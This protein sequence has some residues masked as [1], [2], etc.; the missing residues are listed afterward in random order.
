MK[1]PPSVEGVELHL[2]FGGDAV[3]VLLQDR[4]NAWCKSWRRPPRRWESRSRTLV[5][6]WGRGAA[7]SPW[8]PPPPVIPPCPA[9]PPCGSRAR[10]ARPLF[11][12]RRRPPGRRARRTIRSPP[13]G[14][15]R[16][17]RSTRCRHSTPRHPT[18]RGTGRRATGST[19]ATEHAA[20]RCRAQRPRSPWCRRCGTAAAARAPPLPALAAPTAGAA[21]PEAPAAPP[22]PRS[23]T[24]AVT[25][26]GRRKNKSRLTPTRTST[27]LRKVVNRSIFPVRV[28]SQ[29]I[30]RS[31]IVF[32]R[33]QAMQV[34]LVSLLGLR[35][36][37]P[38]ACSRGFG[39]SLLIAASLV[40]L[41][42]GYGGD[43]GGEAAG[44]GRSCTRTTAATTGSPAH[45]RPRVPV[46][47]SRTGSASTRQVGAGTS[48]AARTVGSRGR[49]R[50]RRHD[51]LRGHRRRRRRPRRMQ[52]G[53]RRRQ[54]DGRHDRDGG[55]SR[56]RRRRPAP[57]ERLGGPA[58]RARRWGGGR[59]G[60]GT[61]CS[62]RG[63]RRRRYGGGRGSA[64]AGG[65]AGG[66]GTAGGGATRHGGNAGKTLT[67]A[68]PPPRAT[69]STSR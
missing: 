50:A 31:R 37:P 43:G 8:P 26:A 27:R 44:G 16:C 24:A 29:G 58:R 66:A 35:S 30:T 41:G 47:S 59:G 6:A 69:T 13:R 15:R 56:Q 65:T 46:R 64:G 57:A 42:I 9:V 63:W 22:P 3:E 36:T 1:L 39:G 25:A 4:A 12:L 52:N 20:G 17:R 18:A 10:P 40:A 54:R 55:S 2:V 14:R 7:R 68:A 49:R 33:V 67:R 28:A 38:C 51:R 32:R 23:P 62:S 61:A 48:G 53:R 5:E 19:R 11:R 60:T 34:Q 21:P 45:C